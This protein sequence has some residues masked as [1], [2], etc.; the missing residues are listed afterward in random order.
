MSEEAQVAVQALPARRGA[1]RVRDRDRPARQW[2]AAHQTP[3]GLAAVALAA[4]AVWVTARADWLAYP[5]WLAVQ[6]A[7]IVLGPV[8]V[9]LYWLRRRPQSRF[10]PLLVATGLVGCAP[11]ILQSSSAPALF[12]TGVLWEGADLSRRPHADPHV[13]QRS[14]GGHGR[15]RDP[16]RGPRRLRREQRH[17]APRAAARG[18]RVDLGLSR[19]V[20]GQWVA[21]GLRSGP[22]RRPDA[23]HPRDDRRAGVRHD[24]ADR[25]PGRPRH[26]ATPPGAR[27]RRAGR[28]RLPAVAGRLPGRQARRDR[29]ERRLPGRSAGRSWARGRR[30]GTAS[31]SR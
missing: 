17:R 10:G 28:A 12:A 15:A 14:P 31:C 9:G 18:R 8:L 19:G 23:H 20:P 6:K 2:L 24:R 25:R 29:G 21:S 30:S 1:L 7:D 22:R 16:R 11:Y 26:A 4:L 5:G 3:V 27:D 13:S